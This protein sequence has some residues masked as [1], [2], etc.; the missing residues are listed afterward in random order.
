MIRTPRES[1]DIMMVE[2]EQLR[3]KL[4]AA[5][6]KVRKKSEDLNRLRSKIRDNE[7]RLVRLNDTNEELNRRLKAAVLGGERKPV[8][9]NKK[10]INS[11]KW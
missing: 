11:M 2:I 10:S 3:K 9:V 5:E 6:K 8:T 1:M 4:A 7:R